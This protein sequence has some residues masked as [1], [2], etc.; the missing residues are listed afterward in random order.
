MNIW[1]GYNTHAQKIKIGK[2]GSFW[3]LFSF[4]KITGL[5][6]YKKVMKQKGLDSPDHF[7]YTQ[8]ILIKIQ[9]LEFWETLRFNSFGKKRLKSCKGAIKLPTKAV[10]EP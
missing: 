4:I 5:F 8:T 7:V 2:P 9:T 3:L 1:S 10:S 6:G